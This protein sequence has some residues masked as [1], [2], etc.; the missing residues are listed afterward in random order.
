M[1]SFCCRWHYQCIFSY[2]Y[3]A[4]MMHISYMRYSL[5]HEVAV[6]PSD[7]GRKVASRHHIFF[8]NIRNETIHLLK[9]VFNFLVLKFKHV[10]LK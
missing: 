4:L 9:I 10:P 3:V 8:R 7:D 6:L 2:S 1:T 5:T